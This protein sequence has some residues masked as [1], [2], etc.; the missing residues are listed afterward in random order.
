M[1]FPIVGIV[2]IPFVQRW[3]KLALDRVDE[4]YKTE[5]NETSDTT[6]PDIELQPEDALLN[7]ITQ[8]VLNL[9]R[10]LQ[11]GGKI[12]FEA[13]Q[14]VVQE[15]CEDNSGVSAIELGVTHTFQGV[16]G[17]GKT[18]VMTQLVPRL[19]EAFQEEHGREPRILVYHFNNYIRQLLYQEILNAFKE[20]RPAVANHDNL[21]S[22]IVQ[23]HTLATLG[24]SL[25]S[26][27]LLQVYERPNFDE[28]NAVKARAMRTALKSKSG[29]YDMILV[30]EGQDIDEEE[31]HL[32][33]D[34]CREK[35]THGGKS[36]F[37][38]YDDFQAIHGVSKKVADRLGGVNVVEHFLP[39]CV[40]TSKRI[41]DFTVNTCLSPGLTDT[42]RKELWEIMNIP[43]LKKEGLISTQKLEDGVWIDCDFCVFE[44]DVLPDVRTFRNN[45]ECITAMCGEIEALFLPE[46]GIGSQNSILVLCVSA[47]M[48]NEASRALRE[49][50]GTNKIRKRSGE[51]VSSDEKRVHLAVEP[52]VINVATIGDAKGYDADIVFILNPDGAGTASEIFKRQRFYVAAT[53]AKQFLAVYSSIPSGT[54]TIMRDALRAEMCMAQHEEV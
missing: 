18:I 14:N 34:L 38:F 27:G 12:L 45:P 42:E 19:V 50:F 3:T 22:R 47:N 20:A 39:Q 11:R 29:F 52:S 36:L 21:C 1:P 40:R 13:Q 15:L 4:Y 2:V 10:K 32:I 41:I 8:E 30:D 7:N 26:D 44:G 16:A 28:T 49:R 31:F 53:R 17:S 24:Q 54:A 33:L 9:S 5:R 37:V 35:D 43:R 48:V 25:S 51:D 46:D 6:S 23:I